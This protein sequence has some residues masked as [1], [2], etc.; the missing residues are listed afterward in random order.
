MTALLES[1]KQTYYHEFII[2]GL[3]KTESKFKIHS[4]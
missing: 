1:S 2:L 4:F 3:A